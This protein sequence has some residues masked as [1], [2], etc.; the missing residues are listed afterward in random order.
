[1]NNL[2]EAPISNDGTVLDRAQRLEAAFRKKEVHAL[3][4]GGE[5]KLKERELQGVLNARKRVDALFD[6][7]SFVESGRFAT[8]A[9]S[10]DVAAQTPADGKITGY[11]KIDG[12]WCAVVSND[13]TVKGASSSLTNAKKIAHMKRNASLRGMPM[14]FIGESSGARLPDT[15]GARGMGMGLGNDPTQYQRKRET[16][17]AAAVLGQCYGSSFLYTCCSDFSVIRKGAVM[18]VSSPRLVEMAT[19]EKIDPQELGGWRVHTEGTGL[20]DMVVDTDQE[21]VEALKRFLSYMPC[22]SNEEPPVHAVPPGSGEGMQN[23]LSLVPEQRTRVYDMKKVIQTIVDAGSFF[24]LKARFGKVAVTA[25]ARLD[26]R[27]VGIYANNPIHKG[28]VLDVDACDKIQSFLVLC[29]SFNIPIVSLVDTPGFVIGAEAERRK[30]PG[31]IVNFMNALQ[32]VTVPKL[33][34]IIRKTY[35]QAFLNMG[36]GRNSD[37]VAAWPTAEVSF[38]TPQFAANIAYGLNP[39]DEGYEKALSDMEKDNSVWEMAQIFAVQNVIRP[40]DTRDY[41]I[42]MLEVHRTRK[43]GGIGAHELRNWPTSY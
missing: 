30:A 19:N 12:R 6:A 41:L 42:Q 10:A 22:H 38:M 43:D 1:M 36:G 27:T 21:A 39:G 29:D 2:K 32:L 20:I 40:Q 28:G 15:M 5:R 18:A 35:G 31:K 25:L 7:D 23:I 9:M 26:G 16:P 33:S 24:E 13:F 34:V 14:V 8:S 11:G 17:W 37:E 3:A 4:M